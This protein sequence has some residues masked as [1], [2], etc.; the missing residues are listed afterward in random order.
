VA[1][2]GDYHLVSGAG[3]SVYW[4][5][6]QLHG[7]GLEVWWADFQGRRVM[8]RGTQPFAIVPYHRPHPGS[9]PPPPE[10]C[11]KDGLDTHCG[12]APFTALKHGAPN[13]WANPSFNAAVDTDAVVVTVDPADDFGPAHLVITA[14]FQCGWYQY[15]HSW[16]FDGDGAIHARVAMGGQLNP[17]A[18]GT[19]HIHNFYFRVDLD[20]DGQFPHDV[21]EVFDHNS[22]ND[23]GG[24]AWVVVPSQTKLL[25]NPPTARKWRV[26]N[27]L[28]KNAL[29]EFKG[30]EIELPQLAGHDK[31]STGDV[32]VTVYRGDG[33]QQGEMVGASQCSDAEL[34]TNYAVGPLDTVGGSDIVLWL[35]IRAHHE[36]RPK[37]EEFDHLP[38]HYEELSI[39]PRSFTVFRSQHSGR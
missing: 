12:G 35:A 7:S 32:W 23:P 29:G 15:V 31:Y 37:G 36:P 6:A 8:W 39:V 30:Y 34:E 18:P 19:A 13:T 4:R 33:V 20:I 11:Y 10:H 17:F 26:R 2:F 24:D 38:Y 28:A 21:A 3:W 1:A 22:L 27:T 25:A 14:K 5:I 16:E 9:E